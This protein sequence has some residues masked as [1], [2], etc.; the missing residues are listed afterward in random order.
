[1]TEHDALSLE[2]NEVRRLY[3]RER[4]R[5]T[6]GRFVLF[7]CAAF[8]LLVA[9]DLTFHPDPILRRLL[10]ALAAAAAL[11][12]PLVMRLRE[13]RGNLTDARVALY[14]EEHLS[15]F[16]E[17]L[18]TAASLNP[19]E[20]APEERPLAEELLRRV[21]RKVLT[22]DLKRAVDRRPARRAMVYAA[23]ALVLALFTLA[24]LP[25]RVARAVYP[26][27][28][29]DS[30]SIAAATKDPGALELDVNPKS[31]LVEA[32]SS[33]EVAAVANRV[34]ETAPLLIY[35][36]VEGEER[37]FTM[38]SDADD[39]SFKAAIVGIDTDGVY[40]VV[41]GDVASPD[42]PIKTFVRPKILSVRHILNLPDYLKMPPKE[43]AGGDVTALT[44]SA[45]QVLFKFN[46]PVASCGVTSS[47]SP[48]PSV[49]LTAEEAAISFTLSESGTYK[50][51]LSDPEGY[52]NHEG[53][54]FTVVAEKDKP[55]TVTFIEPGGDVELALDREITLRVEATDDYGVAGLGLYYNINGA[56]D[57]YVDMALEKG[58]IPPTQRVGT[59]KVSVESVGLNPG[60]VMTYY[61]RAD[62]AN[63][64][65]GPGRTWTK[66]YFIFAM[67]PYTQGGSASGGGSSSPSL[68]SIQRRIILATA[69][70]AEEPEP[71]STWD[72]DH[73]A[74]AKSEETLGETVSQLADSFDRAGEAEKAQICDQVLD[75]FREV[76]T[77][78]LE[79]RAADALVPEQEALPL[80]YQIEPKTLMQGQGSGSGQSGNQPQEQQPSEQSSESQE[81]LF[82]DM[83]TV[84]VGEITLPGEMRQSSQSPGGPS[85]VTT[86]EYA[87][88]LIEAVRR[89]EELARREE[90]MAAG[91]QQ[92]EAAETAREQ[93][94]MAEQ[95]EQLADNLKQMAAE[96]RGNAPLAGAASKMAE[97]AA[98]MKAAG[99]AAG[100][101]QQGMAA[102]KGRAAAQ[103]MRDA[104][105]AL[106][107][108]S[109]QSVRER[110]RNAAAEAR[111]LARRAR[112]LAEA[113]KKAAQGGLQQTDAALNEYA[114]QELNTGAAQF[115]ESLQQ[116]SETANKLA[117]SNAAP[118][119]YAQATERALA[120]F[121][122]FLARPNANRTA[123]ADALE[124]AAEL[125]EN[126]GGQEALGEE[127][128][129]AADLVGSL[130]LELEGSSPHA[131]GA[132]GS[133]RN[134]GAAS[135]EAG[136][137][138]RAVM[139]TNVEAG[140][141]ALAGL[142]AEKLVAAGK[143]PPE[144]RAEFLRAE[145]LPLAKE[146]QSRLLAAARASGRETPTHGGFEDEYPAE[147]SEA[148]KE[149]FRALAAEGEDANATKQGRT[150]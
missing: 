103:A 121:S 125:L 18:I 39:K 55:P 9:V 44:G 14:V 116:L 98:A 118:P 15:G 149:Y 96:S 104:L 74:I 17:A 62:D 35:A 21:T 144:A 49:E 66:R 129:K 5:L 87:P 53:D 51:L 6:L 11:A 93:Q 56:N 126:A 75:L 85:S 33:A 63:T 77:A 106:S 100:Q 119:E 57:T 108:T 82:T 123:Q 8:I 128:V 145:A 45:V 54:E 95:A 73:R 25:G 65:T 141:R 147:Y 67:L 28:P 139:P 64:L 47:W 32:G 81:Q 34:P 60:D 79:K 101:G 112:D 61:A 7:A 83:K 38:I 24:L 29:A 37:S 23:V 107:R 122:E 124:Q 41:A 97:A 134:H 20:L 3:I 19:S 131:F 113:E 1:M 99:Q 52:T 89:M 31:L 69:T 137:A 86:Q 127:I 22:S 72:F 110:A 146:L 130:V 40:R 148:V 27:R 46:K 78:L 43:V 133:A 88:E 16:D 90:N 70:L 2:L 114:R 36:P 13:S 48:A 120:R 91:E 26:F 4:R 71:T 92:Q 80:L 142:L 143:L 42:Y 68:T 59:F 132:P 58:D 150:P 76:R 109:S 136:S 135:E 105:G 117:S 102:A 12:L 50:V 138:L 94:E 30:E 140:T 115:R 84:K 111:D 10:L